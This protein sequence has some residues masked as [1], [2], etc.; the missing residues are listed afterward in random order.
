[1]RSLLTLLLLAEALLGQVTM[2]LPL[3]V[4]D[5]EAQRLQMVFA[6]AY[7]PRDV[8]VY[9]VYYDSTWPNGPMLV[10]YPNSYSA[11]PF[12]SPGG[13]MTQVSAFIGS[14]TPAVRAGHFMAA[15]DVNSGAFLVSAFW[16]H[17]ILACCL[18][19]YGPPS[20]G[21][22]LLPV[23]GSPVLG[24]VFN[25]AAGQLQSAQT[26]A[27]LFQSLR[28]AT[29]A[30]PEGTLLLDAATAIGPIPFTGSG[31]AQRSLS[32]SVPMWPALRGMDLYLQAVLVDPAA[33]PQ[34]RFTNGIIVTFQ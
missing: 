8:C 14:M 31:S 18:E 29:S 33:S 12:S 17:V 7:P 10:S 27:Y 5:A 30:F 25:L 1:M 9:P 34:L 2:P 4:L 20:N 13:M 3:A 15:M 24:S 28:P 11:C 26:A 32:I 6:Q 16:P 22:L 23:A 21:G 19:P